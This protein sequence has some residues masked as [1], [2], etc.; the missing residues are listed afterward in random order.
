[1]LIY[2]RTSILES[3]AQTVVN[4]VNCVGV[5]GKG[6]AADFK[7]QYPDMFKL[8]KAI[9][10]DRL[11]EPGKLWLWRG[12]ERWVLNF[13]TKKH[14]RR[15]SRLEWIDQGLR[16]FVYEYERRGIVEISFPRLGCGNG[17][18]DWD[19]VRPVMEAH[20]SRLAIPVYIHDYEVDIGVPEHLVGVTDEG[21]EHRRLPESFEGFVGIL[22]LLIE[23]TRGEMRD[24]ESRRSFYARLLDN[25]DLALDTGSGSQVIESDD[26]RG[27]WLSLH[28]G[29]VTQ[30]SLEASAG[31]DASALISLLSLLP[32]VRPIQIQRPNTSEP[33]IALELRR[34]PS[35]EPLDA[36]TH[37]APAWS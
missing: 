34:E 11:L 1:M 24:I 5:M 8:Y 26:L 17:G 31:Q 6:I 33:E 23:Q 36:H 37:L 25:E 30:R 18:L 10:D 15:P 32:S 4:T 27:I 7:R 16:K 14:W 9:C 2:R 19:D 13:P 28:R 29:L 35:S 21:A 3:T 20:L 12:P 22:R